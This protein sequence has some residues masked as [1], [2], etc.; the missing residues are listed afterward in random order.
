MY[1][2]QAEIRSDAGDQAQKTLDYGQSLIVDARSTNHHGYSVVRAEALRPL[3]P[4]TQHLVDRIVSRVD[5]A[6]PEMRK[7]L[8]NCWNWTGSVTGS[9]S[10]QHGQIS[11]RG[12]YGASPQKVHRVV[13]DLCVANIR[14]GQINHHCDNPPCIRPSHLYLGTQRQNMRDASKRGRFHVPHTKTLSVADRLHIFALPS[15]RGLVTEL[16][17]TYGVSLGCISVIRR[18][19]FVRPH[20]LVDQIPQD[21]SV[22]TGASLGDLAVADSGGEAFGV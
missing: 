1:P 6:A 2:A 14:G 5:F 15:R 21:A 17:A 12:R 13:W 20:G 22:E 7:G 19:R 11:I 16:A 18:G 9:G 10:V 8:G 4:T 3:D